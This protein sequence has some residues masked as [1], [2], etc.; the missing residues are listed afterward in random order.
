MLM[1]KLQVR[2][3]V[4]LPLSA[5]DSIEVGRRASNPTTGGRFHQGDQ[6]RG[7]DRP[8]WRHPRLLGLVA[9]YPASGGTIVQMI[10]S[11]SADLNVDAVA[12]SFPA[13]AAPCLR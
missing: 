9:H 3:A 5:A 8:Q 1:S 13:R 2:P 6:R 4:P 7:W 12:R 10:N 11:Q